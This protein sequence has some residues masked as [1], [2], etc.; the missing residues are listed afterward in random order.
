MGWLYAG[1]NFQAGYEFVVD[2]CHECTYHLAFRG[3]AY[4]P[5]SLTEHVPAEVL[6]Q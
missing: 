6:M 1:N 5:S 2:V 3:A 4:R